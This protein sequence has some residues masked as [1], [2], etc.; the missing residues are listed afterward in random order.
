MSLQYNTITT[1]VGYYINQFMTYIMTTEQSSVDITV[2]NDVFLCSIEAKV[3]NK[4]VK[5][6]QSQ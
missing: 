3:P 1:C 2:I 6:F 4:L 5:H